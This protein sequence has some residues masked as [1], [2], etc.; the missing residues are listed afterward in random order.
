[1]SFQDLAE[2]FDAAA[3]D[4]P[5]TAGDPA[6]EDDVDPAREHAPEDEDYA[7]QNYNEEEEDGGLCN[8]TKHSGNGNGGARPSSA[9]QQDQNIATSFGK[10]ELESQLGDLA[11]AS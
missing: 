6:E 3:E 5:G 9:Y 2:A 8:E 10:H 7:E 1:M 4:D 11:I